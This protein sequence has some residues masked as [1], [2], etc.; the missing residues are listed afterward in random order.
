MEEQL[1]RLGQLAQQQLQQYEEY[2]HGVGVW[3]GMETTQ[4]RMGAAGWVQ[5]AVCDQCLEW[6]G[7]Q[8]GQWGALSGWMGPAEWA[9]GIDSGW[10]EAWWVP[11]REFAAAVAVAAAAV[12]VAAAA[13]WSS[14]W[15]VEAA[16]NDVATFGGRSSSEHDYAL[17]GGGS[18]SSKRCK[19]TEQRWDGVS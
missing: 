18:S 1:G 13:A 12:A 11:A 7:G 2:E 14:S 17:G 15:E 4:T 9:G 8:A 16:S 5:P 3:R 19:V 6:M 10:A